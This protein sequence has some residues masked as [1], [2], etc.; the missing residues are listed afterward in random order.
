MEYNGLIAGLGNPGRKYRDTRHNFGFAVLQVLIDRGRE[1]G[2][3]GSIEKSRRYS[4][5]QWR[6]AEGTRWLLARPYSYMN[7][8]GEPLEL[9]SRKFGISPRHLLVVHDDLDLPFGRL[10]LKFD[11]GLAGH[12]GLRSIAEHLGT[13]AFY[14]LR[15]G[16]GRS[17]PRA[18]SGANY[19]LSSFSSEEKR[20]L[21][22]ILAEAERGIR[23]FCSHGPEKAMNRI[24]SLD[25]PSFEMD[26]S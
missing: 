16:I 5:H 9:V 2:E 7:R 3:V 19:V 14:R 6:P 24:H 1:L 4:L 23:L 17:G 18:G 10:R 11:S 15:M 8:S 22:D 26:R 21:P 20:I 13:K 12:N 25:R